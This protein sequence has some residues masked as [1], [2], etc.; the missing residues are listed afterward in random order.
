MAFSIST[1]GEFYSGEF[2]TREAAIAELGACGWVGENVPPV[3][4]EDWWEASDWLEHV[5]CQDDYG[6]DWAADWDQSTA[7]QRVELEKE[8]RAVMAAWLD[9]HCLRPRFWTITNAERIDNRE[10][11]TP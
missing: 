10:A 7:E 8:V 6:G 2:D 4:P 1:D 11:V 9:R 3:Q 5:S